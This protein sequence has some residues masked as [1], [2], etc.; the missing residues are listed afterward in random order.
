MAK[1]WHPGTAPLAADVPAV[2]A[3]HPVLVVHFWAPWNGVDRHFAPVLDAVRAGFESRIAFRSVNVDD[4][5]LT[6]F[7]EACGVVNVPALGCFVGGRRVKTLVGSRPP[8]ALWSEFAALLG[9]PQ[10]PNRALEQTDGA[11]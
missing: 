2:L 1:G 8:G 6:A 10:T 5:D 4:E 9:E 7:C 11:R 3:E